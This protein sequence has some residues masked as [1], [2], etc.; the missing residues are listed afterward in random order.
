ME[1]GLTVERGAKEANM[2]DVHVMQK[3]YARSIPEVVE[4][5]L[6]EFFQLTKYTAIRRHIA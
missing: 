4:E 2:G 6:Y 1:E 3:T 5:S